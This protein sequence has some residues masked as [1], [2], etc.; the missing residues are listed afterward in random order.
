MRTQLSVRD[1]RMTGGRVFLIADDPMVEIS[2][3]NSAQVMKTVEKPLLQDG[4]W[5]I[6]AASVSAVEVELA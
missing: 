2:H 6:P 4:V 1:R 3:L 5:D